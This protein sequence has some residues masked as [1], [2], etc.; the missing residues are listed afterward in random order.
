M[1]KIDLPKKVALC[2]FSSDEEVVNSQLSLIND[3]PFD[4]EIEKYFKYERFKPLYQTFSQ[5]YNEAIDETDSEFMIFMLPKAV[6]YPEDIN[7]IIEKLCSGYSFV[8]IFGLSYCGFTKELIRNIGML[9]EYFLS[10]EY[11]D[12]DLIIRIKLFDKAI[13]WGQDWSKYNFYKSS[14]PPNRGSSLTQ[15]WRKWRWKDNTLIVSKNLDKKKL[16]SKRHRKTNSE[17]ISSWDDYNQ[18]YGEGEIWNMVNSCQIKKTQ[19]SESL[20][21]SKLSIRLNLKSGIFFIEM[22]SIV[23]TAISFFV[24]TTHKMG[25]IPIHM[26]LVYSNTW[27]SVPISEFSVELRI[28]HDGNLIL[29]NQI[30]SPYESELVFNLPSSI[31][32]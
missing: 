2:F 14:C 25:R 13:Y 32:I 18:S 27:Y 16:I 4:F 19:L 15:F 22:N 21:D 23:E 1:I 10:G 6:I 17:I 31:L 28:Y 3:Y 24:L 9:D 30:D 7:S 12:N 20:V 8:S 11:E 26:G 5:M 29:L